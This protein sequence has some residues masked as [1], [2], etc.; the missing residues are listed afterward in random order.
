MIRVL[1]VDDDAIFRSRARALLV[2]EG[3]HAE[4][5]DHR[6]VPAALAYLQGQR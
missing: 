4:P 3:F 5:D 1:L 6:R 2:A